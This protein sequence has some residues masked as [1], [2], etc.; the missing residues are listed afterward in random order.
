MWC[1]A[2][3]V[4]TA[5]IARATEPTSPP[6]VTFGMST[7][8]TGTVAELGKEVQKGLLTGFDRANRTGGVNGFRLRLETLDDGYEPSRTVP[9]VR[10]LIE[11]ENVLAIVGNVG[12]PTAIAAIPI[13]DDHKT[14]FF[15]PFTGAAVLR[16]NPPDRYIINFRASYIEETAAMI[17]AL[18]DIAGLKPEE[19]AFFTQR[20]GYGDSGFSGGMVALRRHGLKDERAIAHVRYERNSLAVEDAVAELLLAEKTP[21][22]ILMVGTYGACAKFIKLCHQSDLKPLFL[23]VSFVGSAAL[24]KALVK[25][26]AHIIITQ[27]VPDPLDAKI[28]IA[29]EYQADLRLF[30]PTASAGYPDFEGYIAARILTGAIGKIQ[31][32]VTREAIIDALEGFG[33]FDPGLGETLSLSR[34]EHQASHLVWPTILRDGKFVS[35]SWSEI[36][37]LVNKEPIP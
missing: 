15:A 2:L 19:I 37:D 7:A 34:S 24:A 36:R 3:C 26:E 28:P 22:A 6:E 12:T 35:F 4:A 21:R 16:N 14:L 18:V 11:K 13:V 1:F 23:G 33:K 20:D 31:G 17:D 32:S 8:L 5:S 25:T 30:D 10:Q 29:R 27:V 9:N